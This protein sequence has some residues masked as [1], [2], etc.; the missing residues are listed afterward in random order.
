[1]PREPKSSLYKVI[2][3]ALDAISSKEKLKQALAIPIY[4]NAMYLIASMVVSSLLNLVFWVVVARFYSASD[5]GFGSAIISAASILV[6]L[7]FLGFDFSLIRFIPHADN[8]K[9]MINTTLTFC[10]LVSLLFAAIFVS[11]L[12]LW[13]PALGFVTES[14]IYSVVFILFVT[15]WTITG[16]VNP[17]FVAQ[18]QARFV[19]LK[20]SISS[21]L[22]IP[23]VILL[24]LFFR[25]GGIVGAYG[26]ATA[27][28]VA[29]TVFLFLPKVQADY[30]FRPTLD[31]SLIKDTYKYSG[32][33]Y[34]ASLLCNALYWV[35]PLMVVNV[36]GAEANAYF[37][38]SF[39]VASLL[40][41]VPG[42]MSWSLFAEGSHF[43]DKLS[44]NTAMAIK[45]TLLIVTP[46]VIL[47]LLAGKWLLLLFG[48]SYAVNGLKLLWLL[49]LTALPLGINTIYTTCLRITGRLRELISIW[50]FIATG[51]LVGSYLLL[52]AT[53]ITGIGYTWL[54]SHT[55]V[56]V[57]V[58]CARR[59]T[60]TSS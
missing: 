22:R 17:V 1:M 37:Y 39:A 35:L 19:F 12:N 2:T 16:L 25:S 7:S 23:L 50:G 10:A 20:E 32:A 59:L 53:G 24:A 36:L 47:F 56:A 11:G 40:F 5:V 43:E 55:I 48:E 33:N 29:I 45:F 18:R 9:K 3:N 30:K 27:V 6:V 52:P 42:A 14:T 44:Q 21:L 51:I 28:T 49:A 31:I 57:Y 15:L 41:S 13:S 58:L 34:M 26:M 8:P 46:G 60:I 4:A 54:G 38:I